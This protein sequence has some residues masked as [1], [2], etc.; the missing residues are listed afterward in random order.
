[1]SE[2]KKQKYEI[3]GADFRYKGKTYPEGSQIELTATEY[4]AEKTRIT[5]KPVKGG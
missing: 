5:L 3:E 2:E 1:M 4:K